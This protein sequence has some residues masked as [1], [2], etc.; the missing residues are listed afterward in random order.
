MNVKSN[1]YIKL[2]KDDLTF[3]TKSTVLD[4]FTLLA[5]IASSILILH[6]FYITIDL[7]KVIK[8]IIIMVKN[9]YAYNYYSACNL[10]KCLC[11]MYAALYACDSKG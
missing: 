7:G 4:I 9:L 6:S 3:R 1:L 5:V 8:Y 2:R 11:I 10:Y